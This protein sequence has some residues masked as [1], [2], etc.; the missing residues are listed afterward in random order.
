MARAATAPAPMM[1]P[2]PP[3][4]YE[5]S[6]TIRK[7]DNN[8][9]NTAIDY[10]RRSLIVFE[11]NEY[12]TRSSVSR[13]HHPDRP[14]PPSR[15]ERNTAIPFR[16]PP[17]GEQTQ[18]LWHYVYHP[19]RPCRAPLLDGAEHRYIIQSYTNV[20][21]MMTNKW[22]PNSIQQRLSASPPPINPTARCTHAF[23]SQM[24]TLSPPTVR[25]Q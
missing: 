11:R 12:K 2:F 9:R 24:P 20:L 13:H 23:F 25:F 4:R 18:M 5:S 8:N 1:I 10:D 21:N 17:V 16:P 6:S 22:N 7:K 3:L 15:T 14:Q 19:N